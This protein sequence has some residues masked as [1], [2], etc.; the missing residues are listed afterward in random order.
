MKL[1]VRKLVETLDFLQKEAVVHCD[2]K[3]DNV[4]IKY[5]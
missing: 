3:P 1:F 2:L 5:D 4:L